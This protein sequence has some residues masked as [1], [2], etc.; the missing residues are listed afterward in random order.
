MEAKKSE[1]TALVKSYIK[2]WKLFVL[3][4]VICVGVAGVYILVKNPE[5]RVAANILIK[6][7][8]KSG[9]MSGLASTMM[10]GM[11]FG[12]MLSV[13]GSAV[14]DELE[15]I[16]SYSIIF[17]AVKELNLNVKYYEGLIKTKNYYKDAP[18]VVTSVEPMMADTFKRHVQ[19][20]IEVDKNQEVLVE[21][22]Y[23]RKKLAKVQSGFPV[24]VSTVYGDFT[25]GKTE[26]F[27]E[28]K[29]IDMSVYFTGYSGYTQGLMK[30][31]DISIASKKA[32]V[33]NMLYE[34]EIPVRGID[35]LNAIIC[36]YN[37]YGIEEKNITA[38]R[39]AAFLQQ[40]IDLLDN[41]LKDIERT[42][43]SYK[44]TNNLTDIESEAR[45]ILE[46]SN[47]FK[48]QLIK[49]ETNFAVISMIEDFLKDPANRY[50]VVPMSL[51][52][53]EKSAIESLLSYNTLLMERLK[54]LRSTQP[55]NPMIETMNEQVDATR[56]SVI[57]TIQSIKRGIE[58]A[59]NDL[60][61]QEETFMNRIKGMPKQER[62]YIE[63]KRQQEIKQALY[64]YLLQQQEE[65][66]LKLAQSNPKAQIIDKAFMYNIPVK[67]MKKL[68]AV[69]ALLFAVM[70]PVGYL[71]LRK[72]FNSKFD[73]KDS[74][75]TLGVYVAQDL[76]SSD[77]KVLFT[78]KETFA[79]EDFRLLRS[80]VM[81]MLNNDFD[82]KSLLVTSINDGEGKS[83]VAL[84]MA[85]S[86]AKLGKNVLL[87]DADL[88]KDD[89]SLSSDS[90]LCNSSSAGL[91][92]LVR[93]EKVLASVIRTSSYDSNL[94]FLSSGNIGEFAPETLLN[95]RFGHIM[96]ECRKTYDFIIFD[97]AYLFDYSD[98]IALFNV[99][100]STLFVTRANYSDVKAFGYIETLVETNKIDKYLCVVND[101]K[102]ENR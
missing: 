78:G 87:V 77:K 96:E 80:S 86:V 62:E 74:L 17:Q 43:E 40:R 71:S 92:D 26:F 52:I 9:G 98:T 32:N 44:E 97:S 34:D 13:G 31:L 7:D 83:F 3:S 38:E 73:S 101:V 10:K 66:A 48:E 76:H 16:S 11:A 33:I 53:D 94:H 24:K 23:K 63:I 18:L 51:G 12:D 36:K 19:F 28:G 1:L 58:Y 4:F 14:D 89:G 37:A 6:E 5:Y 22:Y 68:I 91:C 88:R 55:G 65:N 67:P 47:D 90:G 75:D 42:I 21:A 35:L 85:L 27:E 93:G 8:S 20:E 56:E 25:I 72:R 15:V 99:V 41:N 81:L 79:E 100:D 70:L 60:R 50:A 64:L 29:K 82:G 30:K 69:A 45:I 54:L 57:V 95:K 49:A 2:N 59:R 102:K 39:T 84:N 46:K 61:M